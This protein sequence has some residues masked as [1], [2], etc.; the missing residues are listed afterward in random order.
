MTVSSIELPEVQRQ[1]IEKLHKMGKPIVFVNC[2]GSAI[3]LAPEKESVMLSCKPGM[4]V[5]VAVQAL[6]E[7]LT[8][9]V[10][11]SGKLP[12]TF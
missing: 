12:V 11:P 8:A 6:A 4:A 3:A 2:S 10:N 5:S 9:K 1:M 7:V